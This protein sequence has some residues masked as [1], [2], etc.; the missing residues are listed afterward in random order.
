ML[1]EVCGSD[2]KGGP[3]PF[4]TKAGWDFAVSKEQRAN[5]AG[6]GQSLSVLSEPEG[7][8]NEASGIHVATGGLQTAILDVC[9]T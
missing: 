1:A 9:A 5:D 7:L 6:A 2:G 3:H 8:G 4:P